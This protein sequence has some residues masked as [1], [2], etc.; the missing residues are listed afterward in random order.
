MTFSPSPTDTRAFQAQTHTTSFPVSVISSCYQSRIPSSFK[1][2]VARESDQKRYEFE[3]ENSTVAGE[4]VWAWW[5]GL[6]S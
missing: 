6:H 5:E 2:I 3:A 1:L 4:S